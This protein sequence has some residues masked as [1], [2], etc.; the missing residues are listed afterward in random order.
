MVGS[1]ERNRRS[2]RKILVR[3]RTEPK[4]GA[5]LKPSVYW[6]SGRLVRGSTDLPSGSAARPIVV[7]L[8]YIFVLPCSQN[9][10]LSKYKLDQ[11]TVL[12]KAAILRTLKKNKPPWA[13]TGRLVA[14]NCGIGAQDSH[15]VSTKL[16]SVD[17]PNVV[18]WH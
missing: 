14:E 18:L 13:M 5:Y 2:G 10:S 7:F 16:P 15:L 8:P 17:R 12:L 3:L 11:Q 6:F 1:L 9:M 4:A